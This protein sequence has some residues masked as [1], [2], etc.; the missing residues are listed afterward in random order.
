[1]D[2][3][4]TLPEQL[5]TTQ[6]IVAPGAYDGLS[7]RLV[8]KAGFSAVYASGGAIARS[9]GVP[10]IGLLSLTEVA[11]R[12]AQMTAVIHI[13]LIADADTGFGNVNNV[14]RT[15]HIFESAGV[16]ALH[17]DDQQSPKRCGHLDDKKLVSEEE[18]VEKLSAACKARKN[19]GTQIIARTDAIAVEGIDSAL[20]RAQAYH[21]AGADILFVEA[22]QSVEQIQLIARSL[23][24][25]LM[26]NLFIGGKTPLVSLKHL[27]EWGYRLVIIPSDTQRAAIYAIQKTLAVIKQNGNSKAYEKQMVSFEE[28]EKIVDTA[29]YLANRD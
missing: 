20:K 26:I 19:P 14:E 3:I 15:V 28:R 12:L 8:E 5:K 23:P 18:M 13:P 24:G 16:A 17:L 10:D 29:S 25:V 1:M 2:A 21:A 22:P 6:L 27:Q 7:A 11:D 4:K 9:T